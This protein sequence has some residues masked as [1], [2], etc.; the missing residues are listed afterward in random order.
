[1]GYVCF[2][3]EYVN[4]ERIKFLRALQ[5]GEGV[6]E[7]IRVKEG[8]PEYLK[9][10]LKRLSEG[11]K[12]LNTEVP[13]VDYESLISK[14]LKKNRIN[15]APA[16]R[17]RVN[18]KLARVKITL[19]NGETTHFCLTMEPYAPPDR[20]SY[21]TG[22]KLST[23]K[24]PYYESEAAKIKSVCRL[25]YTKLRDRAK[26]KECFDCLLTGCGGGILE[27][28]V[29]NLFIWD[30]GKFF[31]PPVSIHRLH[32]IMERIVVKELK[33]KNISVCKKRIKLKDL[34]SKNGL[35]I[36]NSLIGVM[37]VRAIG[38]ITLRNVAEEA[39]AKELINKFSPY[40][41][42]SLIN[43]ATTSSLHLTRSSSESG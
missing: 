34:S 9:L 37:P 39:T 29:A 32:G 35:L 30:G 31:T 10:H 20:S 41:Q 19:F 24:H 14:L 13:D 42:E 36:T 11:A 1:V 33:R 12:F 7:T 22:V 3:G 38:K 4:P 17:G 15:P 25:P 26:R 18:T 28:T 6:F 21:T 2:D 5:Y 23:G 27:S 43:E 16:R 8:I 40:A